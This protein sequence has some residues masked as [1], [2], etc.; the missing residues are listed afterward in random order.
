MK[1]HYRPYWNLGQVNQAQQGLSAP[2]GEIDR[3]FLHSRQAAE[4]E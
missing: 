1:R 2:D 3:R 4:P